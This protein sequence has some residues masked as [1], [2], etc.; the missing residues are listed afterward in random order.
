MSH[1]QGPL[2][3][4]SDLLFVGQID[5]RVLAMDATTGD[6]LWDF[7]TGS[8]IAGAP[9]TY[10]VDGEQ[11]VAVIAAGSTNPYGGSVTQGDS[12]WSFKLGGDYETD[13][14]SQEGPD[15]APLTI[16][17]PVG[18][19]AVE[20]STVGNTVLLARPSRTADDAA[21][22]DSVSQ[23]GMQPTHLR[24]PVGATVTFR[25]PGAETFANFPNLKE[26]CAT[27]FFEG[28]F[29]VKLKPGE[30]YQ[31]TFDR[32][33]EY[34]FNDCTDPRPTGKIEVYLTPQDQPGALTFTPAKLN[35]ASGTGLFTG[36]HGKVTAQFDLPAGYTY[37]GRAVLVTPLTKK[38]ID[39]SKVTANKNRIIVQFDA[40]EVDNN[41]PTG[42]TSLTL[43]VNVLNA[44]GVQE[45]LSSTGTVTVVK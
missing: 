27:Q 39:A 31:H 20:G 15:T 13:S 14:G 34:F 19:T 5:G 28:E 29:N 45:Q 6:V 16:R 42:A 43:R 40:T 37:D 23:N 25:N 21:S 12:L 10:E 38:L 3:T 1:G 35:L 44:A 26:H 2:T 9:V 4:A 17:R 18:G 36:V 24:V 32:A 11:Y 30:T 22:R 33:G 41:V 7:Q 8:G